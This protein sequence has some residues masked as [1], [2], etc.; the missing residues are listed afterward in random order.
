M[1]PVVINGIAALMPA[2]RILDARARPASAEQSASANHFNRERN[3]SSRDIFKTNRT[4][5]L[6]EWRGLCSG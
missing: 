1:R 3:R 5:A 2:S 6:S 4:A